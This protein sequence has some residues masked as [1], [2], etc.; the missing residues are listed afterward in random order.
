MRVF[1]VAALGAGLLMPGVAHAEG[2]KPYSTEWCADFK[3]MAE[4]IAQQR[5]RSRERLMK[6]IEDGDAK[7]VLYQRKKTIEKLDEMAKYA[8]IYSAF[9][10]R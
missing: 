7:R 1:L 10:K 3:I 8:A 6:A 9:C 2:P 5:D 4:F